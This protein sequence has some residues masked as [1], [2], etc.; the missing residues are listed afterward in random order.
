MQHGTTLVSAVLGTPSEAA[1]DDDTKALLDYGFSLYKPAKPVK[2]GAE[3]ASPDIS[4]D[5]GELPLV[6]ARAV[7]VSTR[8]GQKVATKIDAPEEI[9]SDVEDGQRVGV[10]QVSVDGHPAGASALLA[11]KAVGAATT[12]DKV[13]AFAGDP[14][15]FVPLGSARPARGRA[16]G[17]ARARAPAHAASPL[18]APPHA[19]AAAHAA[20]EAQEKE[21]DAEGQPPQARTKR[22]ANGRGP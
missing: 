16:A 8:P 20:S 15:I 1:R 7:Q 3:L 4:Y 13:K 17:A 11:T 10:V 5:R 19:L 9:K 12:F 6:A 22:A 21:R 18:A 14:L 2:K